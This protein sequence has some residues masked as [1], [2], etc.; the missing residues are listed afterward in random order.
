MLTLLF[1]GGY[2]CGIKTL[3]GFPHLLTEKSVR[4][5][6]GECSAVAATEVRDFDASGLATRSDQSFFTDEA[7][8]ESYLDRLDRL[9]AFCQRRRPKGIIEATLVG[10]QKGWLPILKERGFVESTSG[11]NSNSGNTV[12]VFHLAYVDKAPVKQERWTTPEPEPVD[13]IDDD[14]EP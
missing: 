14:D 3:F 11:L 8:K 2:C 13:E 12:H 1:H 5:Y 6:P 7:P 4:D 10:T 9:I